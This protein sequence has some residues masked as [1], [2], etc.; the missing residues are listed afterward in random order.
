[1]KR[2]PTR[3]ILAA[4]CASADKENA[5]SKAQSVRQK[6]FLRSDLPIENPKSK[7]QNRKSKIVS[8]N[9]LVR[10]QQQVGW[11]RESDLLR[12]FQVDHQLEFRRLLH[13]QVCGLRTF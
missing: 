6:I 12:S 4:C 9:H 13:R 1:M 7:I 10:P 2:I 8:F 5:K 3:G 11:N